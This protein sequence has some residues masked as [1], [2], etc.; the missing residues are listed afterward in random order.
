MGGAVGV[1]RTDGLGDRVAGRRGPHGHLV[2]VRRPR[3]EAHVGL[4]HRGDCRPGLQIDELQGLG[5]GDPAPRE[6]MPRRRDAQAEPKG[7]AGDRGQIR[8]RSVREADAED[9]P[10]LSLS[11]RRDHQ[12]ELV[13]L[14]IRPVI[15]Q[16]RV[17]WKRGEFTVSYHEHEAVVVTVQCEGPVAPLAERVRGRDGRR[18][19][20]R[21]RR[22][23][24][25]GGAMLRRPGGGPA[26][27]ACLR[28]SN[29]YNEYGEYGGQ[30]PQHAH[31]LP[32]AV[33]YRTA[34]QRQQFREEIPNHQ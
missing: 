4:A 18:R 9:A 20:R 30:N 1:G 10:I 2:A 25:G 23:D 19:W 32:A 3:C 24:G 31:H 11:H 13:A 16:L 8:D 6:V 7:R 22:V 33:A 34:G 27:A 15:G 12:D 26:T 29:Q 17:G 21:R 5:I 14:Q 28:Q